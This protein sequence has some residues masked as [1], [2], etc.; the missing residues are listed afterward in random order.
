MTSTRARV[1]E[2]EILMLHARRAKRALQRSPI[3]RLEARAEL[4]HIL[5]A[6]PT[7]RAIYVE[8]DEPS[9]PPTTPAP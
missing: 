9:S 3:D 8:L 4:L 6:M 2:L 1:A 5:S 7:L